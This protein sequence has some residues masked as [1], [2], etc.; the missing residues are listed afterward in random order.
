MWIGD[1]APEA[2]VHGWLWQPQGLWVAS[3]G[4]CSS[5][6]M[7][8]GAVGARCVRAASPTHA[9][10]RG[11]L[12]RSPSAAVRDDR[13]HRCNNKFETVCLSVSRLEDY[14]TWRR[15]WLPAGRAA[16]RP[17]GGPSLRA[18]PLRGHAPCLSHGYPVAL[19]SQLFHD[20]DLGLYL[21][22][23]EP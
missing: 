12:S 16:P 10:E 15:P 21:N 19:N 9:L 13:R 14:K 5:C 18:R 2:V 1:R 17:V 22:V 7:R 3:R 6:E 23:D 11:V 20:S 8:V 4:F